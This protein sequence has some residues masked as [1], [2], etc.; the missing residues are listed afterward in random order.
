MDSGAAAGS[1]SRTNR[2]TLERERRMRLRNLYS[3]LASFLPPQPRKMSTYEML[4]QVTVYVNQL[5]KRVEELKQ[6]KLQVEEECREM[7]SGPSL[8]SPV[9]NITE[10]DSTLEVNLIA[11]MDTKFALCDIIS[12][13][14]EEGAQVL[15]ATYHNTGNKI[16][17]SFHYQAAYS[18]IGIE[19]VGVHERLKRLH[20]S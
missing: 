11:G 6:M 10:L 19:N 18:R 17:L 7:R 2:S 9:I 4:E 20:I 8:I 13:L 5:R 3:Q 14:E 16:L 1:S 12:I 15:T